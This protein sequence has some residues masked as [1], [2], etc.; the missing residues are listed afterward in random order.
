MTV[1]QR[2]VNNSLELLASHPE[3][4]RF[5]ELNKLLQVQLP[6]IKPNNIPATLV[7][8]ESLANGEIYKPA[9]GIFRHVNY[10]QDSSV[11]VER[12]EV[13]N[14][15]VTTC[16]EEDYY[17][18]FARWLVAE[19]D[20]CTEAIKLGGSKFRDKWGTPDVIGVMKPKPSD[21]YKYAP[22]IV[23]VEIKTDVNNL[24]T[25]FGQACAYKL[26]SHKSYIVVPQNA[27]PD[28]ISRLDSLCMI[29]GI[30][31]ILFNP[32]NPSDPNF[33]IKCRAA[34]HKPDMFYVNKYIQGEI[35][36]KLL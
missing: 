1:K 8:L 23:S 15:Q 20:E 29:F 33:T 22:E 2:I 34:V 27:H 17:E 16:R 28:D 11:P 19:L 10:Q 14:P 36:N 5:S 31:L 13:V 6:E 21:V 30:G 9:K 32:Q 26:F 12:T 18:P 24:I 25:A 3:G 4:L 35:A 7:L